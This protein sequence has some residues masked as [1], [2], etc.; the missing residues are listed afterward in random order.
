MTE[1][2]SW[3]STCCRCVG[4]PKIDAHPEK[5]AYHVA[6]VLASTQE[7]GLDVNHARS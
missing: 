2:E 1:V 6:C 3:E 4:E 5:R 7:I